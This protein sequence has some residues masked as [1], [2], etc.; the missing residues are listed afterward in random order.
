M[1]FL[2]FTSLDTKGGDLVPRVSWN[3]ATLAVTLV[4]ELRETTNDVT[5]DGL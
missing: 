4:P 2:A 3:L 1:E 5:A